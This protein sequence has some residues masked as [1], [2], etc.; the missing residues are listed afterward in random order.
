MYL[1]T[2]SVNDNTF[3]KTFSGTDAI[4]FMVLPDCKPILLGSVTT[5]SYS[6]YRDKKPVTLIGKINVSGYT[7]GMRVIAGSLV[8]TMV[9]QHLVKD[10]HMQ[11]PYIQSHNKV[12]ADELPMFDIMIICASEYGRATRMMIYGIDITDDSQVVSIQDMFIENTF[13]FVARD[14]D[15]FTMYKD[16]D[17][18]SNSV[19]RTF[20]QIDTQMSRTVHG[21]DM[22][23][24]NIDNNTINPDLFDEVQKK[25]FENGRIEKVSGIFDTETHDAIKALQKEYKLPVTGVLD[26]STYQAVFNCSY[27]DNKEQYV[28]TNIDGCICYVDD[29]LVSECYYI[30]YKDRVF[31]EIVNDDV[32]KT[33][34]NGY[35]VFI[36]V[37]DVEKSFEYD[38]KVIPLTPCST[39]DAHIYEFDK[40]GVHINKDCYLKATCIST[41]KDGTK[42]ITSKVYDKA[43]ANNICTLQ[44]ITDAYIYDIEKEGKPTSIQYI[45]KQDDNFY[46]WEVNVIE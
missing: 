5:I 12:K 37:N 22:L 25:L 35:D 13:N 44:E 10:I 43:I 46:K 31:C 26:E 23:Y 29:D 39:V 1:N 18:T 32:L 28:I 7:R 6:M 34:I 21:F 20:R 19:A 24:Y 33:T 8:F 42:N 41:Y 45:I 15:E 3:Y 27:N 2:Y 30:H 40:I 17:S 4:A 14:I 36:S 38:Y 16:G 9:N 11:V